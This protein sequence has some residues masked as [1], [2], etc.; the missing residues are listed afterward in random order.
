MRFLIILSALMLGAETIAQARETLEE[1]AAFA[2][3]LVNS[4]SIG[5]MATV[6]PADHASLAGEPFSLQEY[7]AS[8]HVNGSLTLL[9]LP[10]SRHSQNVLLS[11]THAASVSV[12]SDRPAASRPRVSLIGNVTVFPVLEETPDREAIQAC[13]V[14]QHP[15]ARW[16]LPG[17]REPHIAYWARFDPHSVYYVGG[18]GSEHFIG[19]IPLEMYQNASFPD[20]ATEVGV[21][22]RVLVTQD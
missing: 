10:I 9:F 17:P 4:V 5:N 12:W 2:R 13:Y 7:Y 14:A 20:H 11:P 3:Q 19:N 22:G 6:Y 8:C 18:F 21:G 16:W 1:A 15:D